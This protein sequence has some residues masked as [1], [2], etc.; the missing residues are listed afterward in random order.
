MALVSSQDNMAQEPFSEQISL[1]V[2]HYVFCQILISTF[3]I[4]KSYTN[5][6]LLYSSSK[7]NNNLLKI[8][9]VLTAKC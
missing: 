5:N 7:Q 3:T 4:E 9:L 6:V 2:I 1:E 8:C